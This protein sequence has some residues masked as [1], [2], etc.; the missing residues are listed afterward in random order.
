MNLHILQPYE[1]YVRFS[2]ANNYSNILC[3]LQE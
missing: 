2:A 3:K 1:E